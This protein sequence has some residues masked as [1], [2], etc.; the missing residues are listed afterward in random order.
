MHCWQTLLKVDHHREVLYFHLL[1]THSLPLHGNKKQK[2]KKKQ[3]VKSTLSTEILALEK[4][5]KSCFM[6]KS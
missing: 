2:N 6:I 1:A 4:A 3:V 5:L